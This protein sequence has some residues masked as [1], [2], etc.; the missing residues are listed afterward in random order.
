MENGNLSTK[1]LIG[2][3]RASYVQVFQ[4]KSMQTDGSNPKYS[5]SL[6]IPKSETELIKK[7]RAAIKAAYTA[8]I[9]SK[10]GG[11]APSS[12][13][14]PLRDGDDERSD[15]PEYAD[16]YFLNASCK[17]KPGVTKRSGTRMVNGKKENII[18]PIT[19][20]NEFYSGCWVYASVNF[21][22]FSTSGNKGVACGLNN[23]LKVDDG[24]MLGGRQSAQSD[25]GELDIPDDDAP[26][27]DETNTNDCPY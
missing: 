13:K 19:D 10:F 24:D 5:I 25:F 3:V 6:I 7:I 4:P 22:A 11:K 21:F 15:K 16:S 27:N 12:W 26:F 2:K 18:V 23:V 8:G 17:T 1:C 20:E 14:D 9:A